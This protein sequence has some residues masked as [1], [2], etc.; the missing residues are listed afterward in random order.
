MTPRPAVL[1]LL[2]TYNGMP[3]IGE[4]LDSVLAQQGVDVRVLAC[5]D[6]STDGTREFLE[7]RSHDDARLRLLP[8]REGPKGAA[9]NFLHLVTVADPE[10][11]GYIAF[12]DQDDHWTPG[13]LARQVELMGSGGHDGVSGSV[14]ALYPDGTRRLVKK[15][16][17]QRDL[18][19]ICESPGPGCTHLLSHRAWELLRTLLDEGRVDPARVG[20]HDWLDYAV[21][22]GRGWSWFID[23]TPLIEYRQHGGN[24]MGANQGWRA[25]VS[26]LSRLHDGWYRDQFTV[27]A[28]A[29]REVCQ[30]PVRSRRLDQVTALLEDSSLRARLRLA[31]L[32]PQLR[33]R[34]RD[35][36][37]LGGL[38]L[39]GI[40]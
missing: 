33:R 9:A 8:P 23:A 14:T 11:G 39:L 26:R 21:V 10:P 5:D 34:R 2:A 40:W 15:N 25:K 16:F 35:G 7:G 19:F 30:D 1:V 38:V 17:P 27:M 24:E 31:G 36:M 18:D 28:R 6:G 4:Q 12:A 20:F 32:G 3:W 37:V 22:R 29:A 13:K